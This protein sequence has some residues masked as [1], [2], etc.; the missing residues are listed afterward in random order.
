[1]AVTYGSKKLSRK[2]FIEDFYA[3]ISADRVLQLRLDL[4]KT[5]R[6]NILV[7]N[8]LLFLTRSIK[9]FLKE[10]DSFNPN[11]FK[12]EYLGVTVTADNKAEVIEQVK[13]TL[14]LFRT[15]IVKQLRN[16]KEAWHAH[17][18]TEIL[19]PAHED[20]FNTTKEPFKSVRAAVLNRLKDTDKAM[21]D[22]LLKKVDAS[23]K[24]FLIKNF[25]ESAELKSEIVDYVFDQVFKN[26]SDSQRKL[27]A[28][29]KSGVHRGHGAGAGS[30]VS[31]VAV[32]EAS[33]TLNEVGQKD[34]I[35]YISTGLNN[36]ITQIGITVSPQDLQDIENIITNW[37]SVVDPNTGKVDALYVPYIQ[38]QDRISNSSVDARREKLVAQLVRKYFK[39]VRA[40]YL[41]ELHSSAS[42]KEQMISVAIAPIFKNQISSKSIRK[43]VKISKEYSVS[44]GGLRLKG[45]QAYKNKISRRKPTYTTVNSKISKPAPRSVN[46]NNIRPP[47][48]QSALNELQLIGMLNASLP[49]IVRKN[50]QFPA[51][52]NRTGL[53]SESVKVVSI[54]QTPKGF[55]SISYT[56]DKIPY[57]VFEMGIGKEPWATPERDPRKLIDKSVRELAAEYMTQRFYTK[58]V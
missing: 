44:G 15:S 27:I 6:L 23:K 12:N 45:K 18:R 52:Q 39:N 34:L 19:G 25:K 21:Y 24:A 58:R 53:F 29:V 30:A 43:K 38:F 57:Q 4:Q 2:D 51:L 17:I 20:V 22:K 55:P 33:S 47:R 36:S 48:S 8:N 1:M 3:S 32:A 13:K 50:M 11:V 49:P 28:L 54:D 14:T 7:F 31:Y 5:E 26:L 10:I 37:K 40:D 42:L 41:L 56:Y 16:N 35:N 9:S 46:T